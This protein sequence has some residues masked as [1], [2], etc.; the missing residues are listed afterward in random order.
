LVDDF[1]AEN[2]KGRDGEG[3]THHHDAASFPL[4][5]H[6]SAWKRNSR[7]SAVAS[8]SGFPQAAPVDGTNNPDREQIST[9]I[10]P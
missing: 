8:T 9:K 3:P 7:K 6:R 10:V 1:L 4:L 5:I 2:G